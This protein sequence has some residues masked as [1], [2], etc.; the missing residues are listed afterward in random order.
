MVFVASLLVTGNAL[1]HALLLRSLP[2][3][4]SELPQPPEKIEMWFS[5]PLEADFSSARLLTTSG[6]ETRIDAAELD[7]KPQT[8]NPSKPIIKVAL[9]FELGKFNSVG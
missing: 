6:E 7:P 9:K 2:V 3:A 8:P 4:N 1:A 5:E